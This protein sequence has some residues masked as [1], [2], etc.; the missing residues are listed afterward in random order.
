MIN[1]FFNHFISELGQVDVSQLAPVFNISLIISGILFAIFMLCLG[2]YFHK[3]TAYVT[4]AI[5]FFSGIFLSL[6]G[7]F[8]MNHLDIHMQVA[9][10]FFRSG[11]LVIILFTL[12]IIFDKQHKISKWLVLPGIITILAFS[13]FL[14]IPKIVE[15]GSTLNLLQPTAVRPT[16]FLNSIL[17]WLVFLTVLIWIVCISIYLIKHKTKE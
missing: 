2:L 1:S 16:F 12:I 8:P 4:S 14:V 17:E 3:I 7:I 13:S 6:V 9:M 10:L 11:L 5:G 15:P